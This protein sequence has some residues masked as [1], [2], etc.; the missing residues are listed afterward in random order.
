MYKISAMQVNSFHQHQPM[1][2]YVTVWFLLDVCLNLF[3]L[4]Y[5]LWNPWPKFQDPK[6]TTLLNTPAS[7][8]KKQIPR[9]KKKNPPTRL[10]SNL[11]RQEDKAEFQKSPVRGRP[12]VATSGG[13][14]LG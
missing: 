3:F 6:Q 7:T 11:R 8:E 5:V 12:N 2:Q 14:G 10:H 1:N 13:N 4:A 9:V